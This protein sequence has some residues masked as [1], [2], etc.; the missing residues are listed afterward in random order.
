MPIDAVT[1]DFICNRRLAHL[2]TADA[3]GAPSVVPVCYAFDG[4]HIYSPLDEK[5]KAVDPLSLK[6]ARNIASNP[7]VSL[8]FDDYD[9]DWSKLAY[10]LVSAVAEIIEPAGSTAAEHKRAVELLREKYHQYRSMAID[11][12]PIIKVTPVRARMWRATSEG[13]QDG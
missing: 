10:V 8:V 7:R 6:R 1:G 2:A 4:R 9:E 11:K 12:R 5:P 3:A 13:E